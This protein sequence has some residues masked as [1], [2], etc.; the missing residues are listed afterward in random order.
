MVNLYKNFSAML[1][2][3]LTKKARFFNFCQDEIFPYRVVGKLIN[4]HKS[5]LCQSF[6]T[7]K[8]GVSGRACGWKR[9]LGKCG[10]S[11]NITFEES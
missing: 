9:G 5:T 11:L 10:F 1:I 4:K 8:S 2:L 3:A 7:I 6:E